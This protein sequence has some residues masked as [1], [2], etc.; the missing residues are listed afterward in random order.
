MV[1]LNPLRSS[2]TALAPVTA[3]GVALAPRS[4]SDELAEF[5]AQEPLRAGR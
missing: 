3:V 4:E 1:G 5:L 2:A